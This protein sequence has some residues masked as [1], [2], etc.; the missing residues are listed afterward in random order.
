MNLKIFQDPEKTVFLKL[1]YCIDS[2]ALVCV[3]EEGDELSNGV[4]CVVSSE[5]IRRPIGVEASL[6]F[7]LDGEHKIRDIT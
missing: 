6:G 4:L 3:N 2:V 1:V 7:K 5:G